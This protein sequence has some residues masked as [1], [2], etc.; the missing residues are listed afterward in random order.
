MS[1]P[2]KRVMIVDDHDA[3]RRGIRAL[4]ETRHPHM[5][6]RQL[7]LSRRIARLQNEGLAYFREGLL[8]PLSRLR[9]SKNLRAL[10]RHLAMKAGE[11]I[12]VTLRE[13]HLMQTF[14]RASDRY[15]P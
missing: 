3:L 6:I 7:N 8:R 2:I 4:I 5:P 10:E 13:L 11:P 14:R 9:R 1:S 15:E 12:P